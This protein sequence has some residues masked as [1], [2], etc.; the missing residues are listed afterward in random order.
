[1]DRISGS[2]RG[3]ET[4]KKHKVRYF[5]R[6]IKMNE[7]REDLL[8]WVR[9]IP[10]RGPMNAKALRYVQLPSL[11]PPGVFSCSLVSGCFSGF[12]LLPSFF[13]LSPP[14]SFFPFF[15]FII[16]TVRGLLRSLMAMKILHLKAFSSQTEFCCHCSDV[17]LSSHIDFKFFEIRTH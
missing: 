16:Y 4:M 6:K 14:S 17:S 9:S 3:I 5:H 11:Y 15:Y 13:P 8:T 1:M 10:A 12:S 2:S 7:S